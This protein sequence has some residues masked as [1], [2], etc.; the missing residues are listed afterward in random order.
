VIAVGDFSTVSTV[1]GCGHCELVE[2]VSG[3]M[4]LRVSRRDWAGERRCGDLV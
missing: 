4:D 1:I 2:A 3:R